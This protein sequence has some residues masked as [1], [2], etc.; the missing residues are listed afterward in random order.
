MKP[1]AECASNKKQER[2]Q[3]EE[4]ILGWYQ[5]TTNQSQSRHS[6]QILD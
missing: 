1:I 5:T 2:L 4:Y 3:H 6:E